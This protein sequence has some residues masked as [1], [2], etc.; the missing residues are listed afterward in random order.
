MSNENLEH[1]LERGPDAIAK[2]LIAWRTATYNRKKLEALLYAEHKGKAAV[3][4]EKLSSTEIK[5]K[6]QSDERLF[7]LVMDEI[8]AEAEYQRITEKHLSNKKRASLRTA[9]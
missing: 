4:G 5:A 9:Y 2:S 1:E 8:K 7:S 6:V 3:E